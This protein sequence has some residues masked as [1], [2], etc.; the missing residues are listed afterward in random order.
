[1]LA[2]WFPAGAELFNHT[3][4]LVMECIRVS[5]LWFARWPGAYFYVS[6]PSIFATCLYYAILLAVLTGWLFRPKLRALKL[7]AL[8]TCLCIWGWTCWQS[9]SVTRLTVLPVNGGMAIYFDA[10]GRADDLLIDCGTTNSVQSIT[11][12]FLRAQGVNRLPAL[13]LTHG[14]TSHVGGALLAGDLFHLGKLCASPVRFRSAVYRRVFKAYSRTP[15]KLWSVSR[16]DRLGCWSVLHP[17][18]EDHFPQADDNPLVL[19]AL[20]GSRRILLL[21]DLGRPGQ[22]ALLQRTPD[23]RADILVTGQPVQ[24][25]AINDALLDA[26]QPRL[27]IVADSEFPAAERAKPRLQERLSRRAGPVIYTR[28]AGAATIEWRGS[29]WE[30]RT[31]SGMRISSRNP[32]LVPKPVPERHSDGQP[33]GDDDEAD[34]R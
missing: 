25:E 15:E 10:P 2:A 6:A 18:A 22:D 19:S 34:S 31:M 8:S 12:P 26:I 23:P 27:I 14:D 1:L 16:N 4:W 5:S 33:V 9:Y 11:K 20:M 13:A 24:G 21:S 30:V 28:Q 32:T 29:D 3:G 7:A 17:D